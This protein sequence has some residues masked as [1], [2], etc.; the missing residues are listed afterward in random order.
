MPDIK[1]LSL[2]LLVVL[3]I[4]SLPSQAENPKVLMETSLGKITIELYPDKA[5]VTVANFLSYVDSGFYKGTI[6]HR[7]IPNF[8]IQGGGFARRMEKKATQPAI[9]NEANNRLRNLVGTLSMAR[10]ND[11]NSATS[12]FF[13]NLKR[14]P[15]LDYRPGQPGGAGYAVFAKV[16][17]GMDVV[18][19]IAGVK[20]GSVGPYS[21][22]P[23]E[24]VYITD[25]KRLAPPVQAS[26]SAAPSTTGSSP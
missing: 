23:L 11:P 21:D 16:I 4:C 15:N 17:S 12:Q 7:V 10:T 6:F 22:V 13:I 8:V 1:L 5:P 26:D 25:I 2:L 24:D 9:I 3:S 20:T 14:N 19:R 18:N